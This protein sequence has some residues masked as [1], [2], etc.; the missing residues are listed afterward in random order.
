MEESHEKSKNRHYKTSDLPLFNEKYKNTKNDSDIIKEMYAEINSNYRHLAD[1]RFKLLGLVPAISIIA[2]IEITGR[3]SPDNI[4]NI[5]IGL[6]IGILGIRITYAIRIYDKRNDR[7]YNDLISRGRK[8]EDILNIHTGIFKGRKKP[9][10]DN[11]LSNKPISHGRS[12]SLIYSSVFI[13]WSLLILWYLYHM[14]L[15][16]LT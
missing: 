5:I 14:I 3:L 16:I 11:W 2:W 9:Y 12:L 10:K 1:I 8:L 15:Y 4:Q 7:L 13:G 6:I